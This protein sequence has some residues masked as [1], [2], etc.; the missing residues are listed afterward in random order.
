MSLLNQRDLYRIEEMSKYGTRDGQPLDAA[1]L[2][3]SILNSPH[4]VQSSFLRSLTMDT[5]ET[6]LTPFNHGTFISGKSNISG[7]MW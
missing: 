6:I 5:K 3:A 2:S 7:W 4:D 1:N